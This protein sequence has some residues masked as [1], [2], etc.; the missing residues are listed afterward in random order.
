MVYRIV[1]DETASGNDVVSVNSSSGDVTAAVKF[2][3]E[4]A[5]MFSVRLL[6][7]DGGQPSRTGYTTVNIR[8]EDTD[9]RQPTFSQNTY[10]AY[11]TFYFYV[12]VIISDE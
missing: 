5:D 9:D 1:D 2:D 4:S 10:A 7:E 8:I 6:A 3:R 11:F 12:K